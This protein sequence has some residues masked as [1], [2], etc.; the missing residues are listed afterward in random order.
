[1]S[2][3]C[4]DAGDRTEQGPLSGVAA[5]VFDTDGVIVDS[6]REHAA[7]WRTAFDACLRAHPPAAPGARR[8][9]DIGDDYLRH[10]DGRR[11]LDGAASFLASRGVDLPAGSPEDP[12]GTDTVAAVAAYKDRLYTEW[13]AAHGVE[14]FPG[15]MR[16]LRLLCDQGVPLAAVS[17]SRHARELLT[18]CG[19]L[20]CFEAVVDGV[21]A[22]RLGL[23]GKPDPALFLEAARRLGRPPGG[24]AVVEDSL[25]GVEAG[26]RGGFRTVVGVDRAATPA[27]RAELLGRGADVVVDDLA[28]LVT[29]PLGGS[30][31]AT[32]TTGTA[33]AA[34]GTEDT[35]DAEDTED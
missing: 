26:R 19:A 31:D 15:T 21:E 20:P 32:A 13:L 18:R 16:L 10:V 2:T 33:P 6:A 35:E 24:A 11:R 27:T 22:S 17:A 5:V 23:P 7:A 29:G 12:P 3:G 34:T 25:A 14:A 8:P 4:P 1:M 9:F 30:E 28:E